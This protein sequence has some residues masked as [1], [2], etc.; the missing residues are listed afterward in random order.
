MEDDGL[1]TTLD[2]LILTSIKRRVAIGVEETC[3]NQ[4]NFVC[5]S[6]AK[7]NIVMRVRT[8]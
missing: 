3:D 4:V 5:S 1:D 8:Y 7:R 2:V 6:F